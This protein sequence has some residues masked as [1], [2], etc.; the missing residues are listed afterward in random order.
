LTLTVISYLTGK[1]RLPAQQP[2]YYGFGDENEA[3]I[4]VSEHLPL[5][6]KINGLLEWIKEQ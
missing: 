2:D 1:K 4:Y 6:Q 3:I 5:W